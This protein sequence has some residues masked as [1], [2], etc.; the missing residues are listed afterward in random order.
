MAVEASCGSSERF[1]F[2][3][4]SPGTLL[5]VHCFL[6]VTVPVIMKGWMVRVLTLSVT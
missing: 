5:L 2:M 3:Q 4:M 1:N 6:V